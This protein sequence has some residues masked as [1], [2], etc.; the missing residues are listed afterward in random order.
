MYAK[1]MMDNM[2]N[3]LSVN[4]DVDW[5]ERV[6]LNLI[7][8]NFNTESFNNYCKHYIASEVGPKLTLAAQAEKFSWYAKEIKNIYP[9]PNVVCDKDTPSISESLLTYISL[10][11]VHIST[12]QSLPNEKQPAV[13]L[14]E[15]ADKFDFKLPFNLTVVQLALFIELFIRLKFINIEKGK[16]MT[17]IA[18]I[19][20][21]ATTIGT[22]T[23]S[24][25]SLNNSRKPDPRTIDWMI[26]TLQAMI[27]V[28]EDMTLE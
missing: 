9:K 11:L 25:V 7:Y 21:N 28:L 4:E 18:F 24:A 17:T 13:D 3:L 27:K 12:V 10:E 23:I 6:M 19:A 8:L 15:R 22:D 14:T 16:M 1:L 20:Q 5:N 26:E 2:L